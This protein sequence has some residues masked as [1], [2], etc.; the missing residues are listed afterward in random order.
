M[1]CSIGVIG[2]KVLA[3]ASRTFRIYTHMYYVFVRNARGVRGKTLT[4]IT[5]I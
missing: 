4:P 1:T 5:P 2:V 3:G